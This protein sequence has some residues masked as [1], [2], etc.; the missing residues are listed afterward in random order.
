MSAIDVDLEQ[1]FIEGLSARLQARRSRM[2]EAHLTK[3][4]R[5]GGADEQRQGQSNGVAAGGDFGYGG[6]SLSHAGKAKD[7]TPD[8]Q[9]DARLGSHAPKKEDWLKLRS[10]PSEQAAEQKQDA[11]DWLTMRS[12]PTEQTRETQENKPDWLRMR[13]RPDPNVEPERQ[14]EQVQER[15]LRMRM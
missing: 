3:S 7:W 11:R 13:T 10:R 1:G 8:E 15:G 5:S 14:P 9:A 2:A 6:V 4:G 12:R